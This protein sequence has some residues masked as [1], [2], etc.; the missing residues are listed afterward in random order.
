MVLF[1]SLWSLIL[2]LS[3]LLTRTPRADGADIGHQLVCAKGLHV[4]CGFSV[5]L[6]E[7]RGY[8][9]SEGYPSENGFR[10]DVQASLAAR[11]SFRLTGRSLER[12][13]GSGASVLQDAIRQGKWWAEELG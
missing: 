6:L 3:S 4:L 5:L 2:M 7:Y 12:D 13:W 8:G 9:K 1:L 10:K 11:N